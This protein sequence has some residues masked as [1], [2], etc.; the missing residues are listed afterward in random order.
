MVAPNAHKTF[1]K[2]VTLLLEEKIPRF[3]V[4]LEITLDDGPEN[5][6]FPFKETL[7]EL[8]IKH[9]VTTLFQHNQINR[10]KKR[11]RDKS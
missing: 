3:G 5:I 4:P 2:R 10:E 11:K 1:I 8:Y 9:R 7:K 6:G